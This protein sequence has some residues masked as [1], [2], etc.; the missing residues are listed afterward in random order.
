[1]ALRISHWQAQ[2]LN[3]AAKMMVANERMVSLFEYYAQATLMKSTVADEV[4]RN[5]KK[6]IMPGHWLDHQMFFGLWTLLGIPPGSWARD[7]HV[8]SLATFLNAHWDLESDAL[9]GVGDRSIKVQLETAN[10]EFLRLTAAD[11]RVT[12]FHDCPLPTGMSRQTAIYTFA[13]RCKYD[14]V[15]VSS[16]L[17]KVG[18]T[19][20]HPMSC[21]RSIFRHASKVAVSNHHLC[22]F[23]RIPFYAYRNKRQLSNWGDPIPDMRCCICKEDGTEDSLQHLLGWNVPQCSQVA[24]AASRVDPNFVF[25]DMSLTGRADDDRRVML[26]ASAVHKSFL[27]FSDRGISDQNG[28]HIYSWYKT[29]CEDHAESCPAPPRAV[30]FRK[31]LRIVHGYHPASRKFMP[32]QRVEVCGFLT[33]FWYTDLLNKHH[34]VTSTELLLYRREIHVALGSFAQSTADGGQ[35]GCWAYMMLGTQFLPLEFR[36]DCAGDNVDAHVACCFALQKFLDFLSRKRH[37]FQGC[38]ITILCSDKKLVRIVSNLRNRDKNEQLNDIQFQTQ[39]I[40]DKSR[41]EVHR[42]VCVELCFSCAKAQLPWTKWA[43]KLA[44]RE[45]LGSLSEFSPGNFPL[46]VGSLPRI[47]EVIQQSHPPPPAV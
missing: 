14:G 5:I 12:H 10:A 36:G 45:D 25:K 42:D 35:L 30:R 47:S 21:L 37:R 15:D 39:T 18:K 7:M 34:F 17:H 3:M 24:R 40:F 11:P 8:W 19:H 28:G 31:P 27:D 33:K 26:F 46:D 16:L 22:T 20:A 32:L 44:S 41:N 38:N 6:F 43:N 9:T 2:P 23:L 1:M 29:Y 4:N 13:M